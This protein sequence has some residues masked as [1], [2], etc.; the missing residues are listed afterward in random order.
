MGSKRRA[1]P[2]PEFAVC[3]EMRAVT[4]VPGKRGTLALE[5]I[6]RPVPGIGQLLVKTLAIGVCGTDRE[7]IEARFGEAPEGVQR[8]VLGHES[9]GRVAAAPARSGFAEGDLVVGI[10]RH[11]DPVPCAN[12]AFGEW[13]MCRNGL[14]TEHGIKGRHG[15]ASEFFQIDSAMAV[16]V[17]ERLGLAAV[18]LEPASVLAKAWEHIE[19]V[20]RRALW[21]PRRVLVTGAGP[22]GLMAALMGVQRG[23][24]VHVQ[25]HNQDGPKP[26][27]VKDL[28]AA[29]HSGEVNLEFDIV[30]ECTG[31]PA[32]IKDIL[33]A[34][35]P[36]RI[37]CLTGLSPGTSAQT[38]DVAPLNQA[39]VLKNQAVFGTVNANRRH[40]EAAAQ[41]LA[42]ADRAWLNRL[43][44]RKV[45]LGEW[46]KAYEKHPGD[47]KT[48]LL[49][50][51]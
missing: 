8:L 12:C 45:P 1:E 13:D 44:T 6:A 32:V 49:F 51:E 37:V 20:G 26:Q 47:V 16:E 24:E 21:E 40:Y 43:L 18:L 4:I 38:L 10:V 42:R 22:V 31:V 23:L 27:L 14:Y 5:E 30:L 48:V 39:M 41:A 46:Q 3:I 50:P 29:Y 19:R 2:A 36:N 17:D 28:R 25:D 9:L 33:S 11:P 15:F 34:D 35:R 7:L